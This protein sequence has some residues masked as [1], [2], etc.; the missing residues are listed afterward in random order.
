M[1]VCTVCEEEK[2]TE[3]FG[4]DKSRPDGLR[5]RC[6]KCLADLVASRATLR[7]SA[8][9]SARQ[10]PHNRRPRAVGAAEVAPTEVA[11]TEVE[12]VDGIEYPVE[13]GISPAD[14]A[15][16]KVVVGEALADDEVW[17]SGNCRHSHH[18]KCAGVVRSGGSEQ[19]CGCKCH[20]AA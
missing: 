20:K 2:V 15:K 12:V 19:Q 1:K 8:G 10:K 13:T 5:G 14:V 3:E 11:P 7:A 16:A 9:Q 6:N 18:G 4:K 17:T